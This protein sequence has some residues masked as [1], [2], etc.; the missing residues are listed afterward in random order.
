[1][2]MMCFAGE[3]MTPLSPIQS[4]PWYISDWRESGAVLSMT[5]EQRDVYRN[6]LDVCW[7]DGSLPMD[8]RALRKMSFAEPDE[9][10]RAWPIVR[11]QFEEHEGRLYNP[12]VDAKRPEV[13]NGKQARARGA[14]AANAKRSAQRTLSARSAHA[15]RTL[16]VAQ[17][18]RSAHAQRTLLPSPSP[19]PYSGD[20]VKLSSNADAAPEPTPPDQKPIPKAVRGFS[21]PEPPPLPLVITEEADV[22]AEF[23]RQALYDYFG[24]ARGHPD[25][26][27]VRSVLAAARGAPLEELG[28]F[29]RHI[30]QR[31]KRPKSWGFFP[32][33]VR[34]HFAKAVTCP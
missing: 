15:Q 21:R 6:L 26:A 33:V 32:V 24:G 7:R 31:G 9:W 19:S 20:D 34:D 2:T 12:K 5:A 28:A 27:I 25:D 10:E 8:E 23:V 13:L 18:E 30:H 17:A 11:L 22:A 1:M 16:S 3:A 29:L 14:E 4:Y